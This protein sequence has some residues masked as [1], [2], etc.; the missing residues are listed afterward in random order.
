MGV[1]L[2]AWIDKLKRCEYLAEDELKA[3]CEY[4]SLP[5]TTSHIV[6]WLQFRPCDSTRAGSTPTRLLLAHREF[7]PSPCQ[8]HQFLAR[9][10]S[11]DRFMLACVQ[12]KEILV[13]ESNVQPVNSPVTV[14][15][16]C[17]AAAMRLMPLHAIT[18]M[19]TLL[20]CA[21]VCGDIHGQFHDLLKLF[22]TGGEVPGTNYIFMG[23][24]VDR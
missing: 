24:F 23:D 2:D 6:A 16:V 15:P 10:S 8:L 21:Q 20:L 22:S 13:E 5:I 9:P 18:L 7:P 4:V 12:I 19:T 17:L 3:L 1:D 11:P 14:R